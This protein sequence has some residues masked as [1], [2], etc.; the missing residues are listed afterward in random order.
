MHCLIWNFCSR[1]AWLHGKQ[2]DC[3]IDMPFLQVPL[4]N[5]FLLNQPSYETMHWQIL[6]ILWERGEG[7]EIQPWLARQNTN[8]NKK[9]CSC[10]LKSSTPQMGHF[11]IQSPLYM[12]VIKGELVNFRLSVP[13]SL[14]RLFNILIFSALIFKYIVT[15]FFFFLITLGIGSPSPTN[16]KRSWLLDQKI[17]PV[18]QEKFHAMKNRT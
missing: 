8:F 4:S 5:S 13:M 7:R 16:F 11:A 6:T 18:A 2:T 9:E 14:L 15:L 12:Y 10:S 17:P 1:E 3:G